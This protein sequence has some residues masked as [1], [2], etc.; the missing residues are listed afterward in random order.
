[1]LISRRTGASREQTQAGPVCSDAD[2]AMNPEDIPLF[3]ERL[4]NGYDFVKGSR[5][6][7][8][9]GSDDF[10]RIRRAGNS[11]LTSLANIIFG[12]GYTD[13]TFGFN[14]YWR[15]AVDHLGCL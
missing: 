13:L 6:L 8:G 11:W 5:V 4:E 1:M 12:S 2:G 14:G 10:T 7:P 3:I 9:A 15:A